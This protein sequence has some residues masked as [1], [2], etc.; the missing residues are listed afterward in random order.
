MYACT[1]NSKPRLIVSILSIFD[2]KN[3]VWLQ[4]PHEL[5]TE[6]TACLKLI[7]CRRPLLFYS[8][9]HLL[10]FWSSHWNQLITK[11]R[12]NLKN[13]HNKSLFTTLLQITDCRMLNISIFA[14]QIITCSFDIVQKPASVNWKP[15]KYLSRLRFTVANADFKHFPG[16]PWKNKVTLWGHRAISLEQRCIQ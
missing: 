14:S 9:W 15:A 5:G 6:F 13:H 16:A 12:M 3:N 8:D 2:V 10:N 1:G 4:Q 7:D 11:K